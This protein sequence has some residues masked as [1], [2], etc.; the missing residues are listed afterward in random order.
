MTV[1][2]SWFVTC[3]QPFT[4]YDDIVHFMLFLWTANLLSMTILFSSFVS[5][6]QPSTFYDGIVHFML[7]LWIAIYFL[8]LYCLVHSSLGS[9]HL[10]PKL[11]CSFYALFMNSHLLSMR[12]CLVEGH[13]W[14]A[15]YIGRKCFIQMG[16]TIYFYDGVAF[17]VVVNLLIH[18]IIMATGILIV[19]CV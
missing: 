7:F 12:Y 6:E 16:T 11:Y 14:T 9:N 4:S 19:Y 10:L 18:I 5:Y 15:I 13:L 2:F 1:L 3:E 17:C 8:W